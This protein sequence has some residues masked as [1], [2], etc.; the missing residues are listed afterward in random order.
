MKYSL[1][2]VALLSICVGQQAAAQT[3][4]QQALGQE[5][6][7]EGLALYESERASWVASDLLLARKPDMSTLGGYFSYADGDS[8]RTVFVGRNTTPGPLTVA[9]SFSFPRLAI[10]PATARQQGPRKASA[11]EQKLYAMREAVEEELES[12]RVAHA[13][14]QFP[15]NTRPNIIL[16]DQG[17][18]TRAYVLVGPQEGGVL[19][20]GNDFLLRFT[21]AGT[22]QKVERLHNSYLAMRL[23]E[24]SQ[25]IRAGMHS[26]L[27]A[28]PYITPTDICSLLLYKDSF[29][30]PQ[31]IVMGREY[32]SV[33]DLEKQQLT[34]LTQKEF[35][36]MYRSG[37]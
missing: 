16:L 4:K 13:P 1:L 14:Y 25:T 10:E 6:M 34:F 18:S 31:H 22:L 3:P 33:F 32:V 7:R 17:P 35:D 21:A 5:I 15:E 24:G 9:Y 36:K 19:P 20:I 27:P 8:L 23:P 2:A 30:A 28:H 26:H 11:R 12:G 37:K 29:P